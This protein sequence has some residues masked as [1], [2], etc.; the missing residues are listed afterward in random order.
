MQSNPIVTHFAQ[1]GINGSKPRLGGTINSK[2]NR[3]KRW[4]EWLTQTTRKAIQSI[5]VFQRI[6]QWPKN[7][8]TQT[9]SQA[10]RDLTHSQM[11]K[12][13]KKSL[14]KLEISSN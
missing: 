4:K 13:N 8:S 6:D 12:S 1:I 3:S 14:K 7:T 5:S 11:G 9:K 2:T 10:G